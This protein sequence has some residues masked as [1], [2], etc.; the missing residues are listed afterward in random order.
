MIC[1]SI[2][3]VYIYQYSE[4]VPLLFLRQVGSDWVGCK[5][6]QTAVSAEAEGKFLEMPIT[7]ML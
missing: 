6:V 7:V 4:K 5:L 1:N 2:C 3:C